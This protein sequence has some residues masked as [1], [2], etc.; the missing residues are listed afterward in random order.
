M[1]EAVHDLSAAKGSRPL[2]K[3]QFKY[4]LAAIHGKASLKIVLK[5]HTHKNYIILKGFCSSQWQVC[6]G[7]DKILLALKKDP[8]FK[9]KPEKK[10]ICLLINRYPAPLS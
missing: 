3:V 8:L 6:L 9:E 4:T 10:G 7:K 2:W 5:S 1:H